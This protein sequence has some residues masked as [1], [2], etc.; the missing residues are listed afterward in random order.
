MS[1]DFVRTTSLDVGWPT[2][3]GMCRPTGLV[4]PTGLG[5]GRPTGSGFGRT[6]DLGGGQVPGLDGRKAPFAQRSKDYSKCLKRRKIISDHKKTIAEK[7][8]F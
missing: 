7:R 3:S 4:R 8:T 6:S 1:S 5:I 2:K